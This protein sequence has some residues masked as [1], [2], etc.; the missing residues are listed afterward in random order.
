MPNRHGSSNSY[1]YGFQGQEKDDEVKGEGNSINFTFRMYDPRAGRFFAVDPLTRKY[2]HYTPYSFSGNKVIAF[3][4]LEGL[5]EILFQYM[6]RYE[7]KPV[8][9][10]NEDIDILKR[11]DNASSN[12]FSFFGN[13]YADY[14]NTVQSTANNTYWVISGQKNYDLHNDI[15]A[16]FGEYMDDVYDYHTETPIK[17]QLNDAGNSMTDLRNWEAPVALLLSH[18][19]STYKGPNS[20]SLVTGIVEDR[21]T[22]ARSWGLAEDF[23]DFDKAVYTDILEDGT[24]LVQYRLRAGTKG[25]YYAYP[26]TKPE[27]I[28]LRAKDVVET[29]RVIVK[30]DQKVVKSTH[31]KNKKPYYDSSGKTLNGGGLQIKSD[32]LKN[33]DNST[34]EL[35]ENQ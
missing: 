27:A 15:I 10:T 29:Y 31:I 30:G 23:V 25:D 7:Y 14:H 5:E 16:P 33:S 24:E 20:K 4:E 35:I 1:R 28:G 19:I 32:V 34:F 18:K 8:F 11:V 3:L 17:K 12:F 6:D 13:L 21:I 22:L 2:P 26:G 9:E